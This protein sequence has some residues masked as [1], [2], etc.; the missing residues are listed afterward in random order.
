[1]FTVNQVPF[2]NDVHALIDAIV[3]DPLEG[4]D[5]VKD[6]IELSKSYGIAISSADFGAALLKMIRIGN[7]NRAHK[8]VDALDDRSLTLVGFTTR[9]AVKVI[10]KY[11]MLAL[12]ILFLLWAYNNWM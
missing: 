4:E 7:P 8:L 1:M 12:F 2:K 10:F 6:V 5:F 9:A 3:D 11:G